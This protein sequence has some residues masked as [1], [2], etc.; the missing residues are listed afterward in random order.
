M[1][2]VPVRKVC[3]ECGRD[4]IIVDASAGWNTETQQWEVRWLNDL[5]SVYDVAFC[6]RCD[7]RTDI[8]NVPL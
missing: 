2:A 1:S 6:S 5:E 4:G 8:V 7:D 3:E